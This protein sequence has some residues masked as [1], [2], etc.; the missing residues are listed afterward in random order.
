MI[1]RTHGVAT[2]A[3]A[4]MLTLAACSG[5]ANIT[6][7]NATINANA[8]DAFNVTDSSLDLKSVVGDDATAYRATLDESGSGN[9]ILYYYSPSK[10]KS[11]KCTE[12]KEKK[13][14]DIVEVTDVTLMFKADYQ[15]DK[16]KIK[17]DANKAKETAA[18]AAASANV[19]VGVGTTGSTGGG[20]ATGASV[21]ASAFTKTSVIS[22]KECKDQTGK[23]VAAPV[24]VVA[25]ASV[26]VKVYVNA[27]TGEVVATVNA[28]SSTTTTV[29][30]TTT[31]AP[32]ASPTATPMPEASATPTAMPSTTVDAGASS[33][34][35][36]TTM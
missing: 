29:G 27:E 4:A 28:S 18:T 2:L 9:W 26:S 5:T 35:T 15:I 22:G 8:Q 19:N 20:G 31:P 33:T 25:S 17:V 34:A 30:G 21:S 24:Y 11:Y 10:Q 6:V 23:D 1:K 16:A 13:V 7:P 32:S 14:I 12:T 36:T 3:I